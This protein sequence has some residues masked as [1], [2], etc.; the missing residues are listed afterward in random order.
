MMIRECIDPGGSRRDQQSARFQGRSI[1]RGGFVG[2]LPHRP[3]TEDE[4]VGRSCPGKGMEAL[5][6]AAIGGGVVA[7]WRPTHHGEVRLVH[8]LGRGDATADLPGV[9]D[10]PCRLPGCPAAR[11]VA[12]QPHRRRR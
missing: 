12:V 10:K 7:N 2:G 1:P 9:V 6:V 11:R 4:H 8:E 3:R 5:E